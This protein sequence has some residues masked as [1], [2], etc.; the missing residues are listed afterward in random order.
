MIE[1]YA[2]GCQHHWLIDAPAG[3]ISWGR[4]KLCGDEREFQNGSDAGMAVR[5][6]LCRGCT[7]ILPATPEHFAFRA[8]GRA[9]LRSKCR[10]CDGAGRQERKTRQRLSAALGSV[11]GTL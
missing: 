5:T 9:Y 8:G 7:T 1:G 3:P 11:R 4:C 10:A 6:K 2:G